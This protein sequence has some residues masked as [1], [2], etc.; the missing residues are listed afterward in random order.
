MAKRQRE[1]AGIGL[2]AMD[3]GFR[4]QFGTCEHPKALQRICGRLGPAR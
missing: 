3:N 1:K 4:H 2:T